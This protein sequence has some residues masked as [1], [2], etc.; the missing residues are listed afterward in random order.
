MAFIDLNKVVKI[1]KQY[2]ELNPDEKREFL[3]LQGLPIVAST[4]LL[5]GGEQ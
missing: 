2:K 5:E 1:F 3:E 4:V